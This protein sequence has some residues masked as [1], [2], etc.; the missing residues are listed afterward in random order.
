MVQD[1][2]TDGERIATLLTG[3]LERRTSD[4]YG[5]IAVDTQDTTTIV[6]DC[7]RDSVLG[8]YTPAPDGGLTVVFE[9]ADGP[10]RRHLERAADLKPVADRFADAAD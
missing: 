8:R 6:R 7:Q 3:E 4:G 9:T 2:L 1:E 10:D 5:R